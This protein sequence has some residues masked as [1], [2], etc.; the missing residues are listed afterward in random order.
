[1]QLGAYTAVEPEGTFSFSAEFLTESK[2]S[3]LSPE[4][5]SITSTNGNNCSIGVAGKY[6]TGSELSRTNATVADDHHFGMRFASW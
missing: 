1:M 5:L 3:E 6:R 4:Y 2:G